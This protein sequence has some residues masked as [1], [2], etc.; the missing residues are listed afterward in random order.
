MPAIAGNFRGV[1]GAFAKRAAIITAFSRLALT[2]RMC[3]LFVFVHVD[4]RL[5]DSSLD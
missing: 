1:P 4:L 3:A 2:R 5:V